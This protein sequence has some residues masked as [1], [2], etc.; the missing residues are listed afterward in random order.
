LQNKLEDIAAQ[1]SEKMYL[2]R[3]DLDKLPELKEEFAI[4]SIPTTMAFYKGEWLGEVKG[5]KW[6]SIRE[7]S[8]EILAIK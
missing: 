7:L 3:V 5:P 4:S 1:N 2:A 6:I 8:D